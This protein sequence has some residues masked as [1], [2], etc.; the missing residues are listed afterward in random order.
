MSESNPN[1]VSRTLRAAMPAPMASTASKAIHTT[2]TTSRR[3]PR[4]TASPRVVAV[5]TL[6]VVAGHHENGALRAVHQLLAEVAEHAVAQAVGVVAAHDDQLGAEF[7]GLFEDELRQALGSV[8]LDIG[9][10]PNSGLHQRSRD[11][12]AESEGFRN[13]LL[14]EGR[15]RRHDT[16]PHARAEHRR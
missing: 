8:A 3:I 4:P 6:V 13:R 9:R 10:G 2:V 11:L 7:L 1:A 16:R 12:L 15:H 14:F 5:A